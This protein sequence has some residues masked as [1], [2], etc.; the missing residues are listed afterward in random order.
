MVA[1][2][3]DR[4]CGRQY[5]GGQPQMKAPTTRPGGRWAQKQRPVELRRPA[6]Q[7]PN[8][9]RTPAGFLEWARTL[10]VRREAAA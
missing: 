8:G 4:Y 1:A 2:S 7:T 3:A 10:P 9:W 6:L 5:D